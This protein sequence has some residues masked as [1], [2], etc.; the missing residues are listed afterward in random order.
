MALR[1]RRRRPVVVAAAAAAAAAA[2]TIAV[3][4]TGVAADCVAVL[5]VTSFYPLMR[6][7]VITTGDGVAIARQNVEFSRFS[8]PIRVV[9]GS[10]VQLTVRVDPACAATAGQASSLAGI[11]AA[12]YVRRRDGSTRALLSDSSWGWRDGDV[13]RLS[14]SPLWGGQPLAQEFPPRGAA[15]LT[16]L[17]PPSA[18]SFWTS[19]V[20][21]L[22]ADVCADA[23][24][25]AAVGAVGG[26]AQG[27]GG[28]VWGT[29]QLVATA[30]LGVLTALMAAL[31]GALQVALR[32]TRRRLAPGGGGPD[33]RLGSVDAPTSAAASGDAGDGGAPPPPP[34]SR[35]ST[36][37]GGGDRPRRSSAAVDGSAA[38]G[39]GAAPALLG[40]TRQRRQRRVGRRPLPALVGG[41]AAVR[42]VDRDDSGGDKCG[43]GGGESLAS[44]I[45]AGFPEP[46]SMPSVL[47]SPA[48]ASWASAG[49]QPRA[50]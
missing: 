37:G 30:L 18:T 24:P 23:A 19:L 14:P 22:P 39:G 34:P 44:A 16:H 17:H 13:A 20:K 25:A 35:R 10:Q 49:G 3:A 15:W 29:P 31:T 43:G 2:T 8:S 9:G 12:V 42:P 4:A 48:P 46:P 40:A 45:R 26:A 21:I 50:T 47:M 11:A 38:G 28:T 36:G 6:L 7:K 27:G 1:P 32:R 33:G 41:R 5:N